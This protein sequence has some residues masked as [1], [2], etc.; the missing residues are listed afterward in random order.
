MF[1]VN[2][3]IFF[4]T[5]FILLITSCRRE[6]ETDNESQTTTDYS[7]CKMGFG[8][9]INTANNITVNEEGVRDVNVYT[10]ANV[11]LFS[12]DTT[13][14]PFNGDTIVFEVDFG[15]GCFDHD[16]RLKQGKLW[17]SYV[18]DYANSGGSLKVVPDNFK[19]NGIEYQGEVVLNNNGNY[20]FE[21]IITGGKCLSSNWTI[22]YEGTTTM[23]WLSG[24]S[25]PA[26]PYDD[27]Y[28]ISENSNGTNR[29]GRSFLVETI[30][31]IIKKSD[32]KWISSGIIDITPSGLATRRIDFG[33]QVCDSLAT[34][35]INGNT[36]NFEMQ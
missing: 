33:N 28:Q 12:G 15:T 34:I 10:C 1:Q 30:T 7:Y 24:H 31:P 21:Q 22:E 8:T 27:V 19:V 2:K 14:W 5:A 20:E 11:T 9:I 3:F 36:F 23:V 25:T 4:F 26:D 32:C 18:S 29:N 17:V 13:N 6:Q 16:G 35:T